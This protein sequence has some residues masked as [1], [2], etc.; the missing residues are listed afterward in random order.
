MNPFWSPEVR[1]MAGRSGAVPTSSEHQQGFIVESREDPNGRVNPLELFRNRSGIV[2][3]EPLEPVMDPVELFRLRC[4]REAE[5]KFAQGIA[6]MT[7]PVGPRIPEGELA[8][9][10]SGSHS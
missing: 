5:Q 9:G 6:R 2:S 3:A 1:N 7:A 10:S 4:I 8:E